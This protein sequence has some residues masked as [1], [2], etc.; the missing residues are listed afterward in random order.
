MDRSSRRMGSEIRAEIRKFKKAIKKMENSSR[1]RPNRGSWGEAA[2]QLSAGATP[3]SFHPVYPMVFT[4]TCRDRPWNF[5]WWLPSRYA[6]AAR[7]F[8]SSSPA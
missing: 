1:V 2:N 8:S 6:A 3:T 5:S 7:L 4:V